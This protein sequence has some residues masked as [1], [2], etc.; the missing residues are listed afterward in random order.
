M[1]IWRVS[2]FGFSWHSHGVVYFWLLGLNITFESFGFSFNK[3][4]FQKQT[5][6]NVKLFVSILS[7][8]DWHWQF[9]TYS[10]YFFGKKLFK[11]IWQNDNNSRIAILKLH[12]EN[13]RYNEM[14][15]MSNQNSFHVDMMSKE[16][17]LVRT[18]LWLQQ[19][20]DVWVNILNMF[21]RCL[22]W[23]E[24]VN[25]KLTTPWQKIIKKD[26]L[27]NTEYKTQHKN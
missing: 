9:R 12:I 7:M 3:Y 2:L 19:M 14:L 20:V 1:V 21:S 24:K 18:E 22:C 26:Q 23:T 10:A 13:V 17:R 27:T 5:F 11:K 6:N 16:K 4:I 25:N 15:H 8:Y